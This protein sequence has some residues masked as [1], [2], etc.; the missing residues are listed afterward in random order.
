MELLLHFE[1]HII[2]LHLIILITL[3]NMKKRI[4]IAQL[5][6]PDLKSRMRAKDL[7]LLVKNSGAK[8]V[9]IDFGG[10]KFATRSFI[11][12]FYN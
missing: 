12:E 11:D 6:S 1:F 5:L 10:V 3:N 8:S 7:R 9:V 2:L 4:D